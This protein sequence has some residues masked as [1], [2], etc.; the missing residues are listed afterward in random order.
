[1]AYVQIQFAIDD[2]QTADAIVESL[3]AGHLVA[4]GQRLG[5]MVSRYW[6]QGSIEQAEEWLVVLKTR[7]ELA[8]RV[9]DAIVDR[10][11]Y[12]TPEVVA[13]PIVQGSA[14]YLG[15]VQEVTEASLR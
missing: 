12:E 5:P 11:P 8:S 3:L 13:L 4:C 6:W 14:A 2:V 9:I 7:S 15:W 1:M 10:H